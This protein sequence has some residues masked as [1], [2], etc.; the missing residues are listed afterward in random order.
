MTALAYLF[1]FLK[2]A[3]YGTTYFFING[4]NEDIDAIDILAL[5]F[6]LSFVVLW[7]LKT[8]RLIKINVGLKDVFKK[9]DKHQF[10]LP[11]FLAALFSPV[12]EMFFETTGST[13][14]TAVT[15]GV[16]ISLMPVASCVFEGIIL[17]EGT[18]LLQKIFLAL[19]IIGVIY[20]AI[21]IR[22]DDENAR[23][24]IWGIVCLVIAVIA[25]PLYL[26][27]SRR[28][29]GKFK[30]LEITYFSCLLGMI[31]FN[32]ISVIKHLW[33]GTIKHYFD[34]YFNPK[35]ILLFFALS[36]VC[37]IFCTLMN[38]FCMSR[39]QAST[40]AAFG[41]VSTIVTILFGVI[42]GE[43]LY[44]FHYIGFTLILIRMVGVSYIAI[45]KDKNHYS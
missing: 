25:G 31:V 30:P 36:I 18:T 7:L 45:K 13:M 9:T 29:S 22:P 39:L 33:Q 3:I 43:D 24:T 38:N 12:I 11:L 41:G 16:I 6:L 8:T 40:V 37:T 27:F 19:G 23:D 15:A 2:N 20:I 34:P 44:P 14:T 35:N 1:T 4:L 28:S 5:R 17:K 32:S 10:I 42:K 26:V 21:N